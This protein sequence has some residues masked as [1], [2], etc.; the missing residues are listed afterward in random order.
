[1]N[2]LFPVLILTP[3]LFVAFVYLLHYG[4]ILA[5]ALLVILSGCS[6]V[7]TDTIGAAWDVQ[8]TLDEDGYWQTYSQTMKRKK[9]DCEDFAAVYFKLLRD[10]GQEPEFVIGYSPET[11]LHHAW[12]ISD[13][14]YYSNHDTGRG[15]LPGY[16]VLSRS[17][18][19]NINDDRVRV[20]FMKEGYI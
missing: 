20:L 16:V 6:T 11:K 12:I 1:M 19:D 15:Q 13:G 8:Y 5:I 3:L 7:Q 4:R 14:R 10:H 17:T 9:G 18:V 2:N